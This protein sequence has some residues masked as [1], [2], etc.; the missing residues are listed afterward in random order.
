MDSKNCKLASNFKQTLDCLNLQQFVDVP[1]HN[2]GHTLD[3]FI[4]DSLSV[5]GLQVYDVGVSDH[6][7]VTFEVPLLVPPTKPKRVITFRNIKNLD[8]TSLSHCLQHLSPPPNSS[9]PS[10]LICYY[11]TS[12]TSILDCI[13]PLKT[14]TVTFTRSAPWFTNKLREMKR[15]GRVLEHACKTSE[16]TVHKLAN[17]EHRRAYAKALSKARSEHYSTVINNDTDLPVTPI[18]QTLSKL[19]PT[20]QQEVENIIHK[21]KT[22]TCRLDPFPSSLLKTHTSSISSLITKIINMSV[23]TGY[24]PN[25]LKIALIKPLLKKPTLDPTLLSNYR[26]ISNLPF[27]SKLLEKVVSIQLQNHLKSNRLYEKFQSGF[28]PSHSTETALIRVT[29]DLLMASDSGS[30]SLLILLD[31]SAAFDTVDHH[32]LLHRLQHFTGLSGTALKWFHSY[33]TDRTEYVALGDVKS[34]PHSVICGVPQGSVLGPTLFNI[35][36]LPLGRVISKHGVN[37]H[38]YADDTQLYL[39]VTPSSSLSVTAARL[40]SCLKEI[41]AWMSENFLQLNGS[42]TEAIQT[43]TAH[44]LRSSPITSVSFFGHI[45]PLSSSVINLGVKFDP[46][47]SFDSHVTTICKTAFFHLRNISK[48]RPSLSLSAAEKLVHAFVSSRLDYCNALLIGIPG[49]SLQKLQYVQNSAARVLM[50]VRKHEHITPILRSL[51]WL[52]IQSHIEYKVLLQT[53]H[54]LHG[55]APTY[56]TELLTPI[57]ST[58]TRSGQQHRLV[59]PRTRLKTMGDRAFQVAAPC[60]WNALPDH[61]RAPQTH[62]S[63][64]SPLCIYS[65]EQNSG[66]G[67]IR[68]PYICPPDPSEVN[69]L[70][71][72]TICSLQELRWMTAAVSGTSACPAPSL[73]TCCPASER[74]SPSPSST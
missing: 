11:N 51:H 34:R 21:S 39:Q 55:V 23:E 15:S 10:K 14:Q 44:Q 33:L 12:L 26:P 27:I 5:S 4:T 72:F 48:L 24:V 53:H 28:R 13:A 58:R 1:T 50:G 3:L 31:L 45:T 35:Y 43:G 64:E 29:N 20:T 30:T 69:H 61:L 32:I 73:M 49:R 65:G 54:C 40:S 18:A 25:S 71:S 56:L 70:V 42:K 52:P 46:H 47:L 41:E 63:R 36:M 59:M 37:F 57:S 68:I 67:I 22:S 7:A 19:S 17:R 38:C 60:L 74:G 6:L 2:R 9:A 66:V 16:L 62:S 8:A